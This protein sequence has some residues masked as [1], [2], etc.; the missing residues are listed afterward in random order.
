MYLRTHVHLNRQKS[1]GVQGERGRRER[2]G[3]EREAGKREEGG[4]DLEK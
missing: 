2:G 3:Q 1:V 4:R